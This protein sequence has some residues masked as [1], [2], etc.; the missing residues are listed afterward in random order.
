M[1]GDESIL[2]LRFVIQMTIL[3]YRCKIRTLYLYRL[4]FGNYHI[5]G[6]R[7]DIYVVKAP[8]YVVLQIQA[9]QSEKTKK[10]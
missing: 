2:G 7:T 8:W 9:F 3:S 1:G 6:R 10:N 4:P 5:H